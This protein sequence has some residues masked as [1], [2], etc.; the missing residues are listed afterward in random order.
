MN[1]SHHNGVRDIPLPDRLFD[2]RNVLNLR[3][4]KSLNTGLGAAAERIGFHTHALKQ[5][6]EE[7]A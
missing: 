5:R 7:V 6:Y 1:S 2:G 3:P 4:L